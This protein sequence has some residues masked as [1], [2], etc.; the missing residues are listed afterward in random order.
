MSGFAP[1][2]NHPIAAFPAPL[3]TIAVDEIE[4]DEDAIGNVVRILR[5]ALRLSSAL[6]RGIRVGLAGQVQFT[7]P[8]VGTAVKPLRDAIRLSGSPFGALTLHPH[9]TEHLSFGGAL[10]VVWRM[11][12]DEGIEFAD[13]AV[14]QPSKFARLIDTLVAAGVVQT[15]SQARVTL[16]AALAL[17]GMVAS[18]WHAT[19]ADTIGFSEAFKEH[20]VAITALMDTF[21]VSDDVAPSLRMLM[22]V[23]DSVVLDDTAAPH[24]AFLE[25]LRENLLLYGAIRLGDDEYVGWVLNEGAPSEYR[26]F[27]FNGF[28][29][30]NGRYY[31]TSREGLYLLEGDT[32]DGDPITASIKTALMDFGTG[33]LKRL[34]DVY[35]AFVGGDT[36][37]L[38]VITTGQRGEQVET[39]YTAS[40]PAGAAMH[41]VNIRIGQGLTSRYWQFEL[42]N[43]DGAEFEIDELAWRPMTLDRRV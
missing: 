37:L 34:P 25:H 30:F 38:K 6:K 13:D 16:T 5:E 23:D 17:N 32:D 20:V 21:G 31:G 1:V 11:L 27:P 2:G 35:V 29:A 15:H 18:G 7:S 24:V 3:L 10:V 14:G 26:N 4:F 42:T 22:L 19:A 9:I 12:I 36:V 40:V 28:T 43:V 33:V 39:L 41:N 8:V